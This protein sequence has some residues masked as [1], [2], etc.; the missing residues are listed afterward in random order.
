MK[1]EMLSA[2]RKE[3]ELRKDE[4]KNKMLKSLYFGGGTPSILSVNEIEGLIG[5]VQ[6]YFSFDK[7]IEITIEANPDDVNESFVKDL[8]ST[9]VNRFSLGIQSFFDE[10]LKFMNRAHTASEAENSI[11]LLQNFGFDNINIDLIYGVPTSSFEQWKNNLD[12]A[13]ELEIQHISSYAL[14]VEPKTALNQW[15]KKKPNLF[16][17]ESVQSRDFFYMVEFLQENEFQHYEISN[18]SKENYHS[19]HNS[20]YW[21]YS[22]YLGIGPSAHSYDGDRFRSWNIANNAKYIKLLAESRLAY[23]KEVLTIKDCYN[24]MIMLGLRT[25]KGLDMA[26]MQRVF[27]EKI[28]SDFYKSIVPKVNEHILIIKD[29]YLKINKKHWFLADGIASDLFIL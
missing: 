22:P 3:I 9:P 25:D 26:K 4:L 17:K 6:K 29:N 23:E 13:V 28:M 21:N 7:N 20:S 15:I 16:P 14:T 12:K 8:K 19:K 18:F 2:M 1:D 10:D 11:K 24:E 27:S 5:Q